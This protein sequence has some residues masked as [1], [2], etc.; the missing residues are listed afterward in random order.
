M[1]LVVENSPKPVT[2]KIRLGWDE[3]SINVFENVKALEKAGVKAIGI[4]ARTAKQLYEGQP[5]YELIRN[6]RDSMSVP[7]IVSGNIFSVEDA[8]K[9]IE[10][11]HADAVMV[12]RGS[13]GNPYL[14]KQIDEYFE[15]GK[16][17]ESPSL[18]DNINYL[19]KF[20]DM[21]IEE[22][23]EERAIRILRGIAPKFFNGYPGMKPLKNA[24]AQN[25]NTKNDL[26]KI[27]KE[28]N[29]K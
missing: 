19:L 3:N 2:A 20:T 1:R 22:K 28:Y 14:V 29:L 5:N 27:L 12:A 9:A 13:L 23:G 17:L 8:I 11:T 10:I 15:N 16:N 21:L 26:L 24:I 18:E 7:L 25:I 4:H 6:L